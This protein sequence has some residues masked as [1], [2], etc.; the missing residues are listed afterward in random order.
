MQNQIGTRLARIVRIVFNGNSFAA[1]KAARME[2]STLHRLL[3]GDV[4]GPRLSTVERLA[5]AFGVPVGWLLGEISCPDQN[6]MPE[7]Y[8]LI[9]CYHRHRQRVFRNEK[10]TQRKMQPN[11]TKLF[12][13][14]AFDLRPG[15]TVIPMASMTGLF[16]SSAPNEKQINLFR[17]AAELETAIVEAADKML[18]A[19][20]RPRGR[21]RRRPN[22]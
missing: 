20:D 7:A 1:A 3:V 21:T 11:S 4:E 16:A 13:P 8:W 9:L 6:E 22:S 10:T 19:S 17:E 18:A 2:A 14:L 12:E 15:Q 5:D